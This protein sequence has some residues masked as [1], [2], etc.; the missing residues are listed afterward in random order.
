MTWKRIGNGP[1]TWRVVGAGGRVFRGIDRAVSTSF[2]QEILSE[3]GRWNLQDQV[4]GIGK[5]ELAGR[6]RIYGGLH[7]SVCSVLYIQIPECGGRREVGGLGLTW[8]D[9]FP[10]I[11]AYLG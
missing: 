3:F 9:G 11:W 4:E 8:A 7:Q 2:S 5:E 6:I 10:R 1:E